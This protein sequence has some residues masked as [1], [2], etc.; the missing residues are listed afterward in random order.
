[1]ELIKIISLNFNCDYKMEK[2]LIEVIINAL[3][4]KRLLK[5][6]VAKNKQIYFIAGLIT[7]LRIIRKG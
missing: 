4:V 2:K 3:K 6:R 5:N 7:S 1:M